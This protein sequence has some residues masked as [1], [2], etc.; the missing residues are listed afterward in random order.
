MD[1]ELSEEQRA[2]A[3]TAREF[4]RSALA[5]HAAEWDR[6][7]IFPREVIAQTTPSG[8]GSQDG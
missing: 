6:E 2:F 5:P 4:A 7:S 8:R 1:F 3:D